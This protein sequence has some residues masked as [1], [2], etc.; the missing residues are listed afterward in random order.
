MPSSLLL[1]ALASALPLL[2]ILTPK[3]FTRWAFSYYFGSSSN[4]SHTKNLSYSLSVHSSPLTSRHTFQSLS[5]ASPALF[6]PTALPAIW[7]CLIDWLALLCYT[8]L[9]ESGGFAGLVSA[10][11]QGAPDRYSLNVC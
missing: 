8:S 7:R 6:L 2:G 9:H 3:I 5:V 4:V 1:G 10:I 11:S